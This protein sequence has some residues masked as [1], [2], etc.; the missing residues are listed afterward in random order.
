MEQVG[1]AWMKASRILMIFVTLCF[2]VGCEAPRKYEPWGLSERYHTPFEVWSRVTILGV[3]ARHVVG[4]DIHHYRITWNDQVVVEL[5]ESQYDFY[6]RFFPGEE[7]LYAQRHRA[8]SPPTWVSREY[9]VRFDRNGEETICADI[10]EFQ[11][12][13][14]MLQLDGIEESRARLIVMRDDVYQEVLIDLPGCP[15]NLGVR[16]KPT[17]LPPWKAPPRQAP[18]PQYD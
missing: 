13:R 12:S 9:V 15:G 7:Y 8:H 17:P 5:T 11:D 4:E 3:G 6:G 2:L 1:A 10:T 18:G 14:L 16:E